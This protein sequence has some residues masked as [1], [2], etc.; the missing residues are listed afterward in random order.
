MAVICLSS[1][2]FT[3]F[4]A[5]LRYH[6]QLRHISI[7]R[8]KPVS[9]KNIEIWS[10]YGQNKD[11]QAILQEILRTL[12][13]PIILRRAPEFMV[14]SKF[15]ASVSLLQIFGNAPYWRKRTGTSKNPK[16]IAEEFW[17]IISKLLLWKIDKSIKFNF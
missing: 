3:N 8:I 4:L 10:G 2:Y 13:R 9:L 1:L 16:F 12:F 15:L 14:L 6:T 5:V 11:M 17:L 7:Y